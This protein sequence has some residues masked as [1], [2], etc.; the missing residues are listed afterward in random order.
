MGTRQA[1]HHVKSI[2]DTPAL[3]MRKDFPTVKQVVGTRSK[4]ELKP[5][6]MGTRQAVQLAKSIADIH[7]PRTFKDFL[8]VKR[9]AETR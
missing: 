8:P 7:A 4:P 1:V 3:R 6:T 5:A 9:F 2:V